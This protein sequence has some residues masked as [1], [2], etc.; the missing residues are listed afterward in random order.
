MS[1]PGHHQMGHL[2]CSLGFIFQ[3]PQ[4]T[5][6]STPSHH[7]RVSLTGALEGGGVCVAHA[8]TVRLHM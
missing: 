6:K 3:G 8:Y 5:P 7:P 2:V 4:C 1:V